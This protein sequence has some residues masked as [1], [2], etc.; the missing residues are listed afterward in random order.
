MAARFERL[1]EKEEDVKTEVNGE[2]SRIHF[3]RSEKKRRDLEELGV[4]SE[5][6]NQIYCTHLSGLIMFQEFYN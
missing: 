4:V 3:I 1:G 2:D 5:E 6:K